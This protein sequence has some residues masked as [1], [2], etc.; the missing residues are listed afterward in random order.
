MKTNSKPK[1]NRN[2]NSIPPVSALPPKSFSYNQ[3]GPKRGSGATVIFQ[4]TPVLFLGLA[5]LLLLASTHTSALPQQQSAVPVPD[6]G[7]VVVHVNGAQKVAPF[8]P[9]YAFFGYD[10]PNYTYTPNGAKLI[11]ELAAATDASVFFRTHLLL[12]TNDGPPGLKWGSTNAYTEDAHGHAIYDWTITDRIFD[13]YLQAHAKPFVEIGFMP[14]ALSSKPAP[15]HSPW[16]PGAEN[17]DYPAGWSY[18]PSDYAKW[19]ELVYQWARHCAEKYG[20]D[21]ALSWYWEVW[22]EPNI[23]YWHG[24][25]EEYFKLY[26]YAVAGVKRALPNARVGGPA[27]TGPANARAAQFLQA[28]LNHCANGTNYV[29]GAKGS[30]LDFVSYHAKGS[31]EVTDARVRMGIARHLQDVNAGLK[32][33]SSFPEFR[34]LPVILSESDP[35]GCAACSARLYP[36]NA[37]RNGPLYASYTAV[38]MKGILDLSAENPVRVEGML[39]WAFQFES[40]PYFD[41]LRTLATNGVDKPILNLF[42][43]TGLLRG[44]RLAASSSGAIPLDAILAKGVRENPDIDVLATRDDQ[45]IS[46]LLWNYHDDDVPAPSAKIALAVQGLPPAARRVWMQHYRIDANHSNSYSAW[47][48]MGSPQHPTPDQQLQL[49]AAGQLQLL[50]SPQWL[51]TN[52]ATASTNFDLPRQSVSLIRLEW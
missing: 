26:D 7:T 21:Q 1:S 24:T 22:N 28:F 17:K 31:P 11:A 42:R 25:P 23:F 32:I 47:Q 46:I 12:A 18:P 29:T 33:I 52:S 36:Q 27:S 35:E 48:A 10:E 40:Q 13:T 39:T 41:G 15:Y 14:Q 3:R 37:Y 50:D 2:K 44:D 38:A 43:M 34:G 6:P 51:W 20:K 49:E 19:G 9:I 16:V 30:A 8:K 4:K 45:G 5:A